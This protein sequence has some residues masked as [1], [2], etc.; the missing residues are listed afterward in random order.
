M[1]QGKF[2]NELA[3]EV[4]EQNDYIDEVSDETWGEWYALGKCDDQGWFILHEDE[5]GFVD[6]DTFG[7]GAD[8]EAAAGLR[9]ERIL[10]MY[11]EC[12]PVYHD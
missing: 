4:Y 1:V 12:A 6:V 7:A 3:W 2:Q 9:W 8:A 5:Q 11:R 10:S